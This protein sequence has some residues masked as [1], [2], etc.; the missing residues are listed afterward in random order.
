MQVHWNNLKDADVLDTPTEYVQTYFEVLDIC[1]TGT[2][3]NLVVLDVTWTM[4]GY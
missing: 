3:V 1:I 2:H 4:Y